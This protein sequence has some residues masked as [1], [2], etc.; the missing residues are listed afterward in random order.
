MYPHDY[1]MAQALT[2][3]TEYTA[4]GH[5]AAASARRLA[6]SCREGAA[7]AGAGGGG[8]GGGSGLCG[9]GVVGEERCGGGEGGRGEG[10]GG[11]GEKRG[12]RGGPK[13]LVVLASDG[14]MNVEKV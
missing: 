3:Y 11:M 10:G 2:L 8:G 5:S 6:R 14:C 4:L 13:R 1:T 7:G 9:A 12:G